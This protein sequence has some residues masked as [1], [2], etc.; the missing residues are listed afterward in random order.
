MTL[1]VLVALLAALLV[2]FE[3]RQPDVLRRRVALATGA[4]PAPPH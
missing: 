2:H 3:L 1:A 4:S